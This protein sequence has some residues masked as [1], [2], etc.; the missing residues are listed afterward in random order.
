MVP[1]THGGYGIRTALGDIQASR[2]QVRVV[3]IFHGHHLLLSAS[4]LE[5]VVADFPAAAE[6]VS[7]GALAP[8]LG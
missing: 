6:A 3:R 2:C 8:L 4:G 5:S 1:I 7:A